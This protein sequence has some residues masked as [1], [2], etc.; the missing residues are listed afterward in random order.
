LFP[1]NQLVAAGCALALLVV[2]ACGKHSA[3]PDAA[4]EPETGP[5]MDAPE[6]AGEDGPAGD[7]ARLP[8]T[9]TV[10]GISGG[11]AMS[12]DGRITVEIPAEA[13]VASIPIGIARVINFPGAVLSP[14]YDIGPAG[15]RLARPARV[16]FKPDGADLAAAGVDLTSV[17]IARYTA[18]GQWLELDQAAV[19][20][21]AGTVKGIT[22]ELSLLGLISGLCVACAAPCVPATCRFGVDPAVPGSGVA[23][24]CTTGPGCSRCLP[25]CD[26]DGDGYCP[27]SPTDDQPGGDCDDGNAAV[28]PEGHEICGNTIDEDC[29]GHQDEGCRPCARDADCPAAMEACEKGVCQ[30]CDGTCDANECRFGTDGV[31][32]RCAPRGRGCMRCVPACDQ[33]GDGFCPGKRADGQ[34]DGDCNDLEAAVS[35]EAV[36]VC[37]N[38]V[39]DDCDGHVD[40]ACAGCSKDLDCAPQQRCVASVCEP[41]PPPCTAGSCRFGVSPGMPDSGIAGQCMP[42]GN[43]CS[44]CIPTCDADGD[45]FCPGSP[46]NDQPGGDCRDNDPRVHPGGPEICGNK[47][48]DNCNDHIDEGCQPC[49]SDADCTLGLQGC[50]DGACDIC[51]TCDPADCHFGGVAGRC[52]TLAGGC[53]RCVPA[54]DQDGDGFCP[55]PIGQDQPGGDCNDLDAKVHPQAREI[56]GNGLDDDCNGRVDDGC[57]VCKTSATCGTLATCS[58]A[59]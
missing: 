46:S 53:A 24:R 16:T 28:H 55:G 13:L 31:P 59:R 42:Q 54:C 2:P 48:D 20:A 26:R 21:A 8:A 30:V 45:G 4:V 27:G 50:V 29:N 17:R 1:V 41:C 10:I 39:D 52:I 15:T 11:T 12:D 7:L 22:S 9:A 38:Q 34:P 33:D 18:G 43:A 6:P 51:G 37:G 25:A 57:A 47:I 58:S 23:G 44:V 49:N 19:S 35:P 3:A 40:E 32:G 56:C 36:E 5:P 14:M